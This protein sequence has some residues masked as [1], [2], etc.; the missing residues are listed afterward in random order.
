MAVGCGADKFNVLFN[1]TSVRTVTG[2]IWKQDYDGSWFQIAGT[3]LYDCY[4]F[5]GWESPG[6]Q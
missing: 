3:F 1:L 2:V 5:T 6:L 4:R